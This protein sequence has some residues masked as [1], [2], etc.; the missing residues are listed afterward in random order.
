MPLYNKGG[1]IRR[2]I[3]SVIG[4]EFCDF[5]LIVVDDGST[6]SGPE[7]VRGYRDPRIRVVSQANAGVSVARNRGIELARTDLIAF[8]DAD[9]EWQ[10]Q[11]LATI[12]GLSVKFPECGVF[13]TSYYIANNKT[14]IRRAVLNGLPPV[15]EEGILQRYFQVAAQSDPPLCSSAIVVRSAAIRA[16]GG[17]PVGIATGEDLLTWAKLA[18]DYKIGYRNVPL[19]TFWEPEEISSRP[20]RVPA[21]PDRVGEEL[22]RL[23]DRR[24]LTAV[25]GLPEYIAH[26]HRMRGVIFLRLADSRSAREELGRALHLAGLRGKLPALFLISLLPGLSAR[27]FYETMKR[28]FTGRVRRGW[29]GNSGAS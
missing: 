3:K 12:L 23:L 24:E 11:F 13:A 28:L 16:V 2:A 18:V 25:A 22:A 5:E 14:G 7:I 6:D 10:S 27:L 15:L 19:A 17:F 4:Q 20:G 29:R 26:W 9:D 1:E 8:L 21:V